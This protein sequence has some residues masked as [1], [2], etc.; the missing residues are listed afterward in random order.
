MSHLKDFKQES[1]GKFANRS[2]WEPFGEKDVCRESSEKAKRRRGMNRFE[3][4]RS[5]SYL[6]IRTNSLEIRREGRM[7]VDSP[8]PLPDVPLAGREPDKRAGLGGG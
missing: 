2:F 8:V 6:D 1:F 3:R 5:E 7:K 4:E